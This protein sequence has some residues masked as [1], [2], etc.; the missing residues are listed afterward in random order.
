M[1]RRAEVSGEDGESTAPSGRP[2]DRAPGISS[3]GHSD[4]GRMIKR[5]FEAWDRWSR[6]CG[7]HRGDD[8]AGV[9]AGD[10]LELAAHRAPSPTGSVVE[11]A[12]ARGD[13]RPARRPRRAGVPARAFAR[14][15]CVRRSTVRR[16]GRD[17]TRTRTSRAPD[18]A[19]TPATPPPVQPPS[20]P[21]TAVGLSTT[22]CRSRTTSTS[23]LRVC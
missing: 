16:A 8:G 21:A 20:L 5:S 3:C 19:V 6:C 9:V 14:A 12:I 1:R 2:A 23:A 11:L 18:A 10:R 15:A 22:G 17:P 13:R 7:R 4:H